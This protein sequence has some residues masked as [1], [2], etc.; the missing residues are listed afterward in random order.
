MALIA[1][2]CV[3]MCVVQWQKNNMKSQST[4]EV[5]ILKKEKA[6][7]FSRGGTSIHFNVSG[8]NLLIYKSLADGKR[9]TILVPIDELKKINKGDIGTLIT[10][11]SRYISFTRSEMRGDGEAVLSS[12]K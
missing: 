9:K 12:P 10:Q 7:W 2:F 8:T 1:S 5:R 6:S 3:V 11:G 4:S